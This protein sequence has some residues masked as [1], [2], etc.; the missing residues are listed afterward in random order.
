MIESNLLIIV[1]VLLFIVSVFFNVVLYLYS[2]Q[3]LLKV[4]AAAEEASDIFTQ[5]DTFQ[6]HIHSVHE[7]PVFYG[8][9]TLQG[10][11]DHSKELIN[12]LSRYE[13]VYSFVQPDLI[14]QLS[15]ATEQTE[16][17]HDQEETT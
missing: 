13:N 1:F 15:Q 6:E 12:F 10:L 4:Y 14:E 2:R 5:L 17:E 8:D 11:M 7:M 3:M 16:E 9:E